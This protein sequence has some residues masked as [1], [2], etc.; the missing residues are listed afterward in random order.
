MRIYRNSIAPGKPLELDE[1]ICL[2][3]RDFSSTYPLLDIKRAHIEGILEKEEGNFLTA[4]CLIE[5][6]VTLADART[7][8][9]FDYQ[10]SVDDIYDLLESEEEDGDGYIFPGNGIELDDFV[11]AVIKS[12]IPL[13]PHAEE[14]LLPENGEG[15]SV[16]EEGS[17]MDTPE[18]PNAFSSIPDDY[19][20]KK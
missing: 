7:G 10:I 12:N 5:A 20:E 15:Y 2:S 19:F 6:L 8:K 4:N 17:A 16:Y 18:E 3:K 14:S 1:D 9:P 13:A 11:F